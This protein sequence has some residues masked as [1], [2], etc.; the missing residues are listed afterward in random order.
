[1]HSKERICRVCGLSGKGLFWEFGDSPSYSICPCCGNEAGVN[2]FYAEG[3]LDVR[4]CWEKRVYKPE[5]LNF[6]PGPNWSPFDQI[7]NLDNK[8]LN[9]IL[10]EFIYENG[11]E[12]GKLGWIKYEVIQ[13]KD[14]L[15]GVI[16]LIENEQLSNFSEELISDL[17]QEV[18]RS[19]YPITP[20]Q[21]AILERHAS[22]SPPP[23]FSP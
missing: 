8:L 13:T 21:R 22:P 5:F 20:D 19:G 2:D 3:V 6:S 23:N 7:K 15:A 12:P 16:E 11:Y 10:L 1:M 17:L 14:L 18:G 4:K 9:E